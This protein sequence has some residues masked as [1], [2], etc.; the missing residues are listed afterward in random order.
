MYRKLR[1]LCLLLIGLQWTLQGQISFD[2][3]YF[4]DNAGTRTECLIKNLDWKNNPVKFEYRTSPSGAIKTKSIENI[5]EF[6]VGTNILKFQ[7]Y[8]VQIDRSSN[9]AEE[10]STERAAIFQEETLLLKVIVEGAASLYRYDDGNLSRFF[11]TVDGSEMTQLVYK[12]Y[13]VDEK[14]ASKNN[15]YRQQLAN[16]LKCG[17]NTSIARLT[18]EQNQLAKFFI[19]YNKCKGATYVEYDKR[20]KREA[21]NLILKPGLNARGLHIDKDFFGQQNVDF[22]NQLSFRMG[23]GA[24]FIMGF[25][26]NKWSILFEPTY[27]SFQAKEEYT[28]SFITN[29]V[30]ETAEVTYRSIEFPVGIRYYIFLN[31]QTKVFVNGFFVFDVPLKTD[32]VYD[33]NP[34]VISDFTSANAAFGAGFSFNRLSAEIRYSTKRNII[35]DFSNLDS[36]YNGFSFILGFELF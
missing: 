36:N 1:L 5:Q 2:K 18:Y 16:D 17:T 25:N 22:G 15:R 14:T 6:G 31:K 23:I 3:G 19:K 27:N 7:K 30:E 10:L 33:Q 4:I 28:L 35:V 24:E 8:Q 32:I 26:R 34:D 11:Y 13:L 9:V 20:T 12:R 29:P 21:F